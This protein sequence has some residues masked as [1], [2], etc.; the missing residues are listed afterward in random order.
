MPVFDFKKSSGNENVP[1]CTYTV[2]RTNESVASV[3][4]PILILD[5]IILAVCLLILP[6]GRLLNSKER[7]GL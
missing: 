3:E 7:K 2:L 5:N 6:E 1:E 4:S